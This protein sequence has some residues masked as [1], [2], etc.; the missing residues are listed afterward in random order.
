MHQDL[1]QVHNHM[2]KL[3]IA[4]LAHANTHSNF[5]SMENDMWNELSVLQATHA[6]EIFIKARI[7][8]E[9][10][11]LIFEQTP[12]STQIENQF[13]DF[14]SLVSKSKTI[15]YQDLP[16]RLWAATGIKL[17]NI[18]IYKSFGLLRNTIQHFAVPDEFEYETID[19]VYKV[20]DPFINE[21]WGLY[22]VDYHEDYEAYEYI[23]GSLINNEVEFLVSP[24]CE[25]GM[26]DI[27]IDWPEN[28]PY[29]KEMLARFKAARGEID[30]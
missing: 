2:L 20:I 13:L 12:R 25:S 6:A 1:K 30:L 23:V 26:K 18:E 3:G 24:G 4:A 5:M 21:C 8:Q 22:A 17:A 27:S 15:Q 11:L 19:F 29:K 14:K 16:E 28:E 9:H 10:P 7:S